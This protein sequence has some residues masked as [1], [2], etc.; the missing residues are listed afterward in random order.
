MGT[1]LT[2]D[3]GITPLQIV[4]KMVECNGRP[5]AKV[6]DSPGKEMCEDEEYSKYVKKVFKI[7]EAK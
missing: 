5:V 1:D 3:V 7:H 6:S 4:I 2:N